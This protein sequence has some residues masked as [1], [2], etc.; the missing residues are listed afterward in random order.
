MPYIII[1]MIKRDQKARRAVA[2]AVTDAVA[3]S[4]KIPAQKIHIV[5]NEMEK[6]QNATAGILYCDDERKTKKKK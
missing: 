4:L 2:K 6:D 5:I 3:A 1:H